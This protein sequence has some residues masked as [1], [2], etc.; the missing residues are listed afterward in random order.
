[1]QYRYLRYT[2]IKKIVISSCT[3]Y[4]V[5]IIF[6]VSP[7]SIGISPLIIWLAFI[8]FATLIALTRYTHTLNSA[9]SLLH[10][11][12]HVLLL[13]TMR[14]FIIAPA[15]MSLLIVH[16]YQ[17]RPGGALIL[18]WPPKVAR[19][20]RHTTTGPRNGPSIAM[21]PTAIT[22]LDNRGNLGGILRKWGAQM[23]AADVVRTGKFESS[24]RW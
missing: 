2:Q 23:Y 19:Q 11:T 16:L 1:M 12:N 13:S 14:V 22:W 20:P 4:F 3:I 15:V 6:V 8:C 24:L 18:P 5:F 21:R 10:F 7:S 9:F 17:S